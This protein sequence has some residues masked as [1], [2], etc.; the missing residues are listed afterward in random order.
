MNY[1]NHENFPIY[2]MLSSAETNTSTTLVNSAV[3]GRDLSSKLFGL[4]H[5]VTK[6]GRG[7][8]LKQV[9]GHTL[10]SSP[11]SLLKNRGRRE[12]G[13]I[14]GKSCRL[15]ARHHSCDQHRMLPL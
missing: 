11:G 14:R 9:P 5:Q 10:A 3:Y 1:F 15:P 6:V 12:P 4:A 8:E 13:N 2:G 7:L